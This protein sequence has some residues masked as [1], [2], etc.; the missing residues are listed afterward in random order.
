[1]KKLDDQRKKGLLDEAQWRKHFNKVAT[2]MLIEAGQ[3]H[4][5]RAHTDKTNPFHE[6][7]IEADKWAAEKMGYFFKHQKEFEQIMHG[8]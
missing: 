2:K 7:E 6:D 8:G 4:P 5:H 1:M 3:T